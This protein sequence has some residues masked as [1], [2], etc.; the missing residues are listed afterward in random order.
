[1][2]FYFFFVFCY[3]SLTARDSPFNRSVE[4]ETANVVELNGRRV[5]DNAGD[6][7]GSSRSRSLP[8]A[9]ARATFGWLKL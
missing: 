3:G 5:D 7:G 9:E 1:M 6:L 8:Y 2:F 4:G